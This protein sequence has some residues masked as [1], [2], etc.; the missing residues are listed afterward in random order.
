ML[1]R[2]RDPSKLRS[3]YCGRDA[4]RL[5]V[6][7]LKPNHPSWNLSNLKLAERQHELNRIKWAS[8]ALS[9]FKFPHE[10]HYERP[11]PRWHDNELGNKLIRSQSEQLIRSSAYGAYDTHRPSHQGPLPWNHNVYPR[12]RN[13]QANCMSRSF[14]Q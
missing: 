3:T 11:A 8:E 4:Y 7:G 6:P 10:L 14:L 12:A 5:A 9:V 13:V 1:V 2:D